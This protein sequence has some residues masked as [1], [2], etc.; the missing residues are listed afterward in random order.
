MQE[1]EAD[2]NWSLF[3]FVYEGWLS[4][5]KI[6]VSKRNELKSKQVGLE[7]G[8]FPDDMTDQVSILVRKFYFERST[9]RN[10]KWLQRV[11]F[12]TV[13]HI[14]AVAWP[15]SR[16]WWVHVWAGKYWAMVCKGERSIAQN[17]SSNAHYVTLSQSWFASTHSRVACSQR[18]QR[19]EFRSIKLM[20]RQ[21]CVES[22]K[23][24]LRA[25]ARRCNASNF[26]TFIFMAV[27]F[28]VKRNNEQPCKRN[29]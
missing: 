4:K 12:S 2:E 15:S 17:R 10:Y 25:G 29:N 19:L 3:A 26:I 11:I 24:T 9:L 23:E 1:D 22:Q 27:I 5:T 21:R 28:L 20:R 18:L 8:N 16:C 6:I 14:G 7:E 13:F